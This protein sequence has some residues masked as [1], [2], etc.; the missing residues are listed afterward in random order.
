[1]G[2]MIDT[3]VWVLA[4][5]VLISLVISLTT[6]PMMCAWLLKPFATNDPSKRPEDVAG[7]P[8]P[9]ARAAPA[10][11]PPL[12]SR[13]A[14]AQDLAGLARARSATSAGLKRGSLYILN[15]R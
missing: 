6:T 7:R 14:G 15:C 11:A 2:L 9:A 4:E 1:M 12:K 5:T 13:G 10:A 3:D 8:A